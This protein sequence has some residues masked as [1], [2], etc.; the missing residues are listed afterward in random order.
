MVLSIALM[1]GLWA[2]LNLYTKIF[3][4]GHLQ[5]EQ[6]QLIHGLFSKISLD[7]RAA[8]LPTESQPP[9]TSGVATG[10]PMALTTTSGDARSG[11][12][13]LSDDAH[14]IE[15]DLV[16]PLARAPRADALDN[17]SSSGPSTLA[18][19]ELATVRYYVAEP[20]L[21]TP[22]TDGF[23]LADV[24]GLVR[25]A[26]PWPGHPDAD[27]GEIQQSSS[28]SSSQVRRNT[29]DSTEM[30]GDASRGEADE[31]APQLLAAEVVQ[32]EFRYFDGRSWMSRWDSRQTGALPRAV[33]VALATRRPQHPSRSRPRGP[34]QGPA[35]A[36][37]P[38]MDSNTDMRGVS[39]FET[40][41]ESSA[42][43]Q[44]L[45]WIINR[46]LIALPMGGMP[47]RGRSTGDGDQPKAFANDASD[48]EGTP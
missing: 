42:A 36:D 37:N 29:I 2:S 43:S 44:Q 8:V 6:S 27:S 26:R 15:I 47:P 35:A 21:V 1:T 3:S 17:R 28:S 48:A 7:L 30:A 45:P 4:S 16:E 23:N 12:C 32:L 25:L 33:E 5:V 10:D 20:D 13:G 11:C 31:N 18:V 39:L 14:W 9:G 41:P 38:S 22:I 24:A 19:P 46:R 40:S 34:T